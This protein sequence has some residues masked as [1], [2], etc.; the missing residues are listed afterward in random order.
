LRVMSQCNNACE[1]EN[2]VTAIRKQ[3]G[4]M[5]GFHHACRLCTALT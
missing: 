1:S 3:F 5:S 2:G 4:G